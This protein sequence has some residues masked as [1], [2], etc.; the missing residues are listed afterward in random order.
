VSAA[1]AKIL[2]P[3]TIGRNARVGANSV[4]ISQ[5]A[6]GKTVVGIPG[7][8]VN[9]AQAP[10]ETDRGIDLN[11][12]VIPDPVAD[13]ITC[14]LERIRLLEQQVGV[15]GCL[16]AGEKAEDECDQCDAKQVCEPAT[17][18]FKGAR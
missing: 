14:L 1:G 17:I 4:V 10:G 11:H 9:S 6:E 3:I 16:P 18:D 8:V 5:V 15:Y 13:A 7:K 12:H 2:G